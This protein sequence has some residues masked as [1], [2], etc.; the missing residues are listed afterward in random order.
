PLPYTTLFRSQPAQRAEPPEGEEIERGVDLVGGGQQRL[1][2]HQRIAVAVR[3]PGLH[4]GL[5]RPVAH[6]V[7]EQEGAQ[8]LLAGGREDRQKIGEE[9]HEVHARL[10][11]R[12]L[13]PAI[14]EGRERR[15]GHLAARGAD[16]GGR[17]GVWGG[18]G[19]QLAAGG[20]AEGDHGGVGGGHVGRRE[21]FAV[22]GGAGDRVLEVVGEAVDEDQDVTPAGR[23]IVDDL[24]G[25]AAFVEVLDRPDRA[26]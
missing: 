1:V 25:E 5:Q 9:R 2:E 3:E 26:H 7:G 8:A 23:E 21:P 16:G 12:G 14:A 11:G 10:A 19:E 20:P 24:L 4:G 13:V 6:A 18:G 15:G 17:G 22:E